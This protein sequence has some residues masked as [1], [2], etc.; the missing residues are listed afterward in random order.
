MQSMTLFHPPLIVLQAVARRIRSVAALIALVPM[1]NATPSA[2]QTTIQKLDNA[3]AL[4]VGS[5]WDGGVVPGTNDLAAFGSINTA[6]SSTLSIGSGVSFLGIVVTNNLGANITISGSGGS[7]TLGSAGIDLSAM[8]IWR[9]FN[10]N[11]A[12][13]LAADQTWT[14]GTNSSSNP[15]VLNTTGVISGASQLTIDSLAGN[16]GEYAYLRGNSTFS[17]G[18]VLGSSGAVRVGT[19]DAS[20][21]GGA[22][23]ASALGAGSYTING[24]IIFGNSGRVGSTNTTINADFAINNGAAGGA[25]NRLRLF[26]AFDMAGG[27]RTV[28]L[29][30]YTNS[31]SAVLSSG[32]ESLKFESAAGGPTTEFSNGTLRFVRDAAGGSGDYVSVRFESGTGVFNGNSGFTVGSNVITVLGSSFVFNAGG[33]RPQVGV[34]AGGYFNLSDTSNARDASIQTLSGDGTVTSLASSASTSTLTIL[35]DAGDNGVFSGQIVDGS[36]L[37][38]LVGTAAASMALTLNGAG[39]QTL[40]GANTYT[41]ATTISAGTLQIGNG[42]TSGSLSASS[43]IVNNGVLAFNRSDTIVQGSD[44]AGGISG[45][46]DLVQSGAGTLTLNAGNSY[47]GSTV[48]NAGTLQIGNSGDLGGGSYAGAISNSGSFVVAASGDQT[49]SGIISGTGSVNASGTGILTLDAANTFSGGLTL[50]SGASIKAGSVDA[51]VSGSAVTS[52]AFGAGAITINGGTIYGNSGLVAS[53]DISINSDFAVNSGAAGGVNSRLFLA[54]SIDMGGATRTVSLGGYDTASSVVTSG[55]E[56]L[57]F[58]TNGLTSAFTNGTIRFV[59]DSGGGASDYAAVRFDVNTG[60]FTDGAGLVIGENVITTLGSSFVFNYSDGRPQV[61]VEADGYFNLSDEVNARN[62]SI[63]LLSG[64]GTVTSLAS[65]AATSTLTILPDAGDNGV[66]SGQ[67]VDG[68][69]LTGLVG[70]AAASMALTLNGAGTQTL[71]GANTYTGAT[72]ISAGTLQI[73]NGGTSGSLSASTTIANNGTLVFHRSDDLVQGT[74]FST[75]AITG[76]GSLVKR[77]AGTLTLNAAN[78]FSGPTSL[79]EGAIIYD[80]SDAIG[81]GTLTMADGTILSAAAGSGRTI[82]NNIVVNGD[83][84]FNDQNTGSSLNGNIDLTGATRQLYLASSTTFNGVISNGS[85]TMDANASFRTMLLTAA[86]TFDDID[87]VRGNLRL[88]GSG[89]LSAGSA[90]N[91]APTVG[92]S[93]LDITNVSAASVTIGSLAGNGGGAL[94]DLGAKEL[95]T[96]GNDAST[97][98]AGVLSNTGSLTKTGAGTMTLSGA[99]VHEGGTALQEG[100]L[101]VA[102][103]S[104]LGTGTLVQSDGTSTVE[105]STSGTVANDMSVHN[106]AFTA[107]GTTLSGTIT[108]NNTTY[109]VGSGLTN[110]ISGLL[111]GSGGVAKTGAGQLLLTASNN[112]TGEVDVQGG[113]LELASASGFSAGSTT[114]VLVA[115]NAVLL[116][117]QSDQVNNSATVSLSGGTI[118]R[119]SDVSEVFGSL[120]LTEDSFLDFGTGTAGTLSFGAY[121]PSALLTVQNF[122]VG[123]TLTFGSDLTGSINDGGLFA[124]DN[125]FNSSWNGGTSTFTITAIPEPSTVLAAAGL[126]AVMLW[127][128]RRRLLKD[129][130]SVLGLRDPARDRLRRSGI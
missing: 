103:T 65:S 113:V 15:N 44:F 17:G 86:N 16:D 11:S 27:E 71:S 66:F 26:G 94:V 10:I 79:E 31:A 100:T 126:L 13:V 98:F 34:E 78:T 21:S 12:I 49:L 23:T 55:G 117:S 125:G 46:G 58:Q 59:R 109:D 110:T 96:G 45:S 105:F 75:A 88:S 40:S 32:I 121:T 95:I 2:G 99:N 69:S 77:G 22:V 128:S 24:G 73:G 3:D 127:P 120:S 41:G 76:T 5:S 62:A 8:T 84:T 119:G 64:S 14:I 30:R 19:T 93:T 60:N 70:T 101:D 114:N 89:S 104:A 80:V 56:S 118:Q 25:N 112:F 18:F 91:L 106:V 67:I 9:T 54:G 29:G 7:L 116:L 35:P 83:V 81:S 47:S 130:K 48:I 124:F 85:V 74:D 87:V 6:S 50:A 51:A 43:A 37:T 20:V 115:T 72:T 108:N 92:E 97:V 39:T 28:S 123:N 122:G 57:K 53:G 61:S 129:A 90:V 42:G 4:D 1:V 36:S 82:G 68:S 33:S 111:T 38:G 52:S 102:N 63:Q 107:N